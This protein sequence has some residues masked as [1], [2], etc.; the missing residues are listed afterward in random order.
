M[1]EIPNTGS[2]NK[3]NELEGKE[4]ERGGGGGGEW[5]NS[6]TILD[7]FSC[8]LPTFGQGDWFHI[9]WKQT[10]VSYWTMEGPI[11]EYSNMIASNH[12]TH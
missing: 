9:L 4:R 6:T 2:S 5:R 7:R 3:K 10:A 8:R 11:K 12:H 1:Y